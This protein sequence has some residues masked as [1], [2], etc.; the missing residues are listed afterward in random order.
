MEWRCLNNSRI[1][2][3]SAEWMIWSKRPDIKQ[4]L[5]QMKTKSNYSQHIIILVNTFC[6]LPKSDINSSWILES[7]EKIRRN[8]RVV[9]I[10]SSVDNNILHFSRKNYHVNYLSK[11]QLDGFTFIPRHEWICIHS[12]IPIQY[13][14]TD[15][16]SV[17]FIFW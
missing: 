9:M 12:C 4:F 14:V 10:K 15:W 11:L 2:M 5:S 7:I 13:T 1:S 3:L 8:Y 16:G 6:F 17:W